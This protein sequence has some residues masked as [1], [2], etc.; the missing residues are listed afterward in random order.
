MADFSR[1]EVP[2]KVR[3]EYTL[4]SPTN[5]VEVTKVLAVLRQESTP[6]GYDDSVHVEARD[7]EIV[8]WFEKEDK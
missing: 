6:L 2:Q 4:E 3:V 5:W 1:R 7:D 8:F